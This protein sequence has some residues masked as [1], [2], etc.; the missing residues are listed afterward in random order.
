MNTYS[1]QTQQKFDI[2]LMIGVMHHID[3]EAVNL[4]MSSIKRIIAEGGRF[5]SNDCCYT[6]GM[7]P[8][9]RLLCMLDRGRYVRGADEFIS[10][11]Q[12]YWK[13]VR[14]EIRTD[15]LRLP[16]SRILFSNTD[17]E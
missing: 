3:D 6:K 4:C 9:A 13:N 16:Y 1:E 15:G 8:I 11:Q 2:V 10:L 7:N 5:V 12:R 14:S 17:E